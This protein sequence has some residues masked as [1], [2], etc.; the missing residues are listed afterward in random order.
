MCPAL[1]ALA[2][3]LGFDDRYVLELHVKKQKGAPGVLIKLE[4]VEK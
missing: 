1:D 4:E 2:D 3:E